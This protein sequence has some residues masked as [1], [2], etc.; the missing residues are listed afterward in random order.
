MPRL[1]EAP[2]E[3][4][5]RHPVFR[6]FGR[7]HFLQSVSCLSLVGSCSASKCGAY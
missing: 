1:R 5:S 4:E 3:P 7:S 2:R 6:D